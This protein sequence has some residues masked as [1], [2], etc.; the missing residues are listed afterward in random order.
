MVKAAC[1]LAAL[2]TAAWSADI[3]STLPVVI[4]S[5]TAT[6]NSTAGVRND[7]L[8]VEAY[9]EQGSTDSARITYGGNVAQVDASGRLL[10]VAAPAV[11]PPSAT[12]VSTT[13]WTSVA[14]NTTVD[15]LYTITNG[16]T[17]YLQDFNGAT[18]FTGS[19]GYCAEFLLYEDPNGNLTNLRVLHVIYLNGGNFVKV[20][21]DTL[22]GNGT[23]RLLLRVT[24]NNAAAVLYRQWRGYEQ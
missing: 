19:G 3:D 24:T 2:A 15:T 18:S 1:L 22:V 20:I 7:R 8:R 12:A 5:P 17:L 13:V 16:K 11:A 14:I 21:S 6:G 23:R 10:V 9:Q 4:S